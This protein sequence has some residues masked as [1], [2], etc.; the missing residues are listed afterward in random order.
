MLI[1]TRRADLLLGRVVVSLVLVVILGLAG[2]YYYAP[3]EYTR[4]GYAVASE[5][6]AAGLRRV[7][8]PFPLS[9]ASVVA[10]NAYICGGAETAAFETAL[11]TQT[12]RSLNAI[13]DG[14]GRF[15]DSVWRG[16]ANFVLMDFGARATI[17]EAALANNGIAARSYAGSELNGCLRFCAA[18]DDA[19]A[20]LVAEV[21]TAMAAETA[22]ANA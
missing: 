5:R 15:A 12:T 6:I 4:V 13:V 8:Q 11:A 7:I 20:E 9:A 16:P 22:A 2:L 21:Q 19:T 3:P 18:D 14:V 17:I 1:F 10:A